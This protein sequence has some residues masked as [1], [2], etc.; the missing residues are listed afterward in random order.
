MRSLI[1]MLE[2]ERTLMQKLESVHRY[3]L[4]TDDNETIDI[5]IAQKKRVERDL[6]LIRNELKEYLG[7]LLHKER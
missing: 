4:R 5:L 6:G 7:D 1:E 2:D 3:L